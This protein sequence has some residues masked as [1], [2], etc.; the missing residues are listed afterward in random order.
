MCACT[1]AYVPPT[2][3]YAGSISPP[4]HPTHRLQVTKGSDAYSFGVLLWSMWCRQHPWGNDRSG[5]IVPNPRFPTF[6]RTHT[7]DTS[8]AH[9]EY[10]CLAEA[11]MQRDPHKRPT[12]AEIEAS[13]ASIFGPASPPAATT[14]DIAGDDDGG[15]DGSDG[16]KG[17]SGTWGSGGAGDGGGGVGG[18][19]P[20]HPAPPELL[21]E[22]AAA[23]ATASTAATADIITADDV[24]VAGAVPHAACPVSTEAEEVTCR[25]YVTSRA[26]LASRHLMMEPAA[27]SMPP[28]AG[29]GEES[30]GSAAGVSFAFTSA[31]SSDFVVA[32]SAA[33]PDAAVHAAAAAAANAT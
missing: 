31:S 9:A 12:F 18:L 29:G 5:R 26:L 16:A 13:L 22:E 24:N 1:A 6:N 17:D 20:P 28:T 2:R 3:M 27:R 19:V 14:A 30:G 11:C 25:T 15:S 21:R 23:S 4:P 33:P 32:A 10:I 7:S 8:R